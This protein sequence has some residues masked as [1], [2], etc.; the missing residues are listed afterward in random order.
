MERA[1]DK[2]VVMFALMLAILAVIYLVRYARAGGMAP[3]LRT[4][5]RPFRLV[6]LWM[7]AK[8]AE[9]SARVPASPTPEQPKPAVTLQPPPATETAQTASFSGTSSRPKPAVPVTY[10]PA[11]G[12]EQRNSRLDF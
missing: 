4:V 10:G 2:F 9:L 3:L 6:D 5:T 7:K 1:F 11:I 8:E 12:T